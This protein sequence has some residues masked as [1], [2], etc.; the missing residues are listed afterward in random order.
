MSK[1]TTIILLAGIVLAAGLVLTACTNVK[2]T[3]RDYPQKDSIIEAVTGYL[4]AEEY[5]LA[6]AVID[7]AEASGALS[8]FTAE[9]TRGR[10]L[11][12]D[13]ATLAQVQTRCAPLLEQDLTPDEQTEVLALLT[14]A[15]RMRSDD[16]HLLQYGAQYIDVCRQTGKTVISNT[17]KPPTSTSHA[18]TPSSSAQEQTSSIPP[19]AASLSPLFPLN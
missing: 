1:K 10:V 14:Y 6:M 7:S 2:T 19:S 13:Q 11:A 5:D 9:L 17:A 4:V 8:P 16:A 3:H 18:P 15:A 12:S